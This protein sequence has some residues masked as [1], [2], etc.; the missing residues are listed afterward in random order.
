MILTHTRTELDPAY[1]WTKLTKMI[2]LWTEDSLTKLTTAEKHIDHDWQILW[3][4]M[5][6]VAD[7][8]KQ[9]H[10]RLVEWALYLDKILINELL[11]S[12]QAFHNKC[13]KILLNV[14]SSQQSCSC[15]NE[16]LK[17]CAVGN[18]VIIINLSA[19]QM[20]YKPCKEVYVDLWMQIL[21]WSVWSMLKM[22]PVS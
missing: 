14:T 17:S 3:Q 7:N 10:Q 22:C 19:F 1:P 12:V 2:L 21:F 18:I 5:I 13:C 20:D 11:F 6:K 15:E 4:L 16:M 8:V 9:C